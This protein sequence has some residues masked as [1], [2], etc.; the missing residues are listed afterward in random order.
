VLVH[1]IA[2]LFYL[3]YKRQNLVGPMFSGR[4]HG[5]VVPEVEAISSSQL[6]KALILALVAGG[7]VWLVLSRA[8][9]AV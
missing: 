8:P 4:K 9:P 3:F 1:V 7:I 5:H 2:I 6:W